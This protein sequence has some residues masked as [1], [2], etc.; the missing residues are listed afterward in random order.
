[1]RFDGARNGVVCDLGIRVKLFAGIRGRFS[2]GSLLLIIVRGNIVYW[3]YPFKSKMLLIVL[4]W[5]L[6]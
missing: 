3:F 6:M 4:C 1:L 2:R 5:M